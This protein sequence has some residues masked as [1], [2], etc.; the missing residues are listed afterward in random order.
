M[1]LSA[2]TRNALDDLQN[3]S[4]HVQDIIDKAVDAAYKIIKEAGL[5]CAGDDRAAE[6]HG[7]VIR[8]VQSSGVGLDDDQY[9]IWD[10]KASCQVGYPSISAQ[11]YKNGGHKYEGEEG[12]L[13]HPNGNLIDIWDTMFKSTSRGWIAF[14]IG[15]EKPVAVSPETRIYIKVEN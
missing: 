6:L 11:E 13:L 7:A 2:E 12:W 1:T 10:G 5:P 8:F 14:E 15:R 3:L 9:I 4:Q